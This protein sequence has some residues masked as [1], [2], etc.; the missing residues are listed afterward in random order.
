MGLDSRLAYP[1]AE[2]SHG[3]HEDAHLSGLLE[4]PGGLVEIEVGE[5][6][7]EL[8]PIEEEGRL[9]CRWTHE[10]LVSG[11][12]GVLGICRLVHQGRVTKSMP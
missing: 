11:A 9:L 2:I 12:G 10:L 1:T 3:I 4:M 5:R 6:V 8:G 7:A